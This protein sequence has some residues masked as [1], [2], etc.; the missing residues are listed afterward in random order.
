MVHINIRNGQVQSRNGYIKK[1]CCHGDGLINMIHKVV[2][3]PTLK[4]PQKGSILNEKCANVGGGF[5]NNN[6]PEANDIRTNIKQISTTGL[7]NSVKIPI[8]KNLAKENRNNI[9]FV[10]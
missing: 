2:P 10:L 7:L 1:S 6:S 9:K 5:Y 3:E 8:I 4:L